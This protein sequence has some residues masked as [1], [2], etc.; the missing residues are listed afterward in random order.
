MNVVI[1]G[2]A[3]FMWICSA[4]CF[5]PLK[6]FICHHYSDYIF[7]LNAGDGKG[8]NIFKG[9]RADIV[10][11]YFSLG[12]YDKWLFR[13]A[14]LITNF[15]KWCIYDKTSNFC[16]TT[17][18]FGTLGPCL[19]YFHMLKYH[20]TRENKNQPHGSLSLHLRQQNHTPPLPQSSPRRKSHR[21]RRSLLTSS[22]LLR[23]LLL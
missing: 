12:I 9:K 18:S 5:H 2:L 17:V 6:F 7:L 4:C 15:L 13:C 23:R 1:D 20:F 19:C 11:N 3:W 10:I 22:S 21:G 8:N 14:K 16:L